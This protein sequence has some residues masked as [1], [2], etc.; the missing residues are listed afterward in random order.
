MITGGRGLPTARSR[1]RAIAAAC[2]AI[3]LI[4]ESRQVP[5]VAPW[6]ITSS[7]HANIH[8][9]NFIWL[10]SVFLVVI[11]LYFGV[12]LAVETRRSERPLR[13]ATGE[14]RTLTR[15]LI[16]PAGG[17]L[18]AE[19][20]QAVREVLERCGLAETWSHL[21]PVLIRRRSNS[22]DDEYW[23]SGSCADALADHWQAAG[24]GRRFCRA[25][26]GL[27]TGFGLFL[28]FL[29]ILIALM[30]V[31][32]QGTQVVGV[33]QLINGLSGKFLSSVI[34]L[35]LA[36]TFT[37]YEDRMALRLTRAEGALARGLDVVFPRLSA[38][39]LISELQQG[40]GD[41][42]R[43]FIRDFGGDLAERLKQSLSESMGPTL[44]RM[45]SVIE[46]LG[47]TLRAAEAGKQDSFNAS[48]EQIT[49]EMGRA[50]GKALEALTERFS[51]AL[52]GFA[53]DQI[54]QQFSTLGAAAERLTGFGETFGKIQ[55]EMTL[56]LRTT[57]DEL[58]RTVGQCSQRM[59]EATA[60]SATEASGAAQAVVSQAADWSAGVA[61]KLEGLLEREEARLGTVQEVQR[62]LESAA[63]HFESTVS[64]YANLNASLASTVHESRSV[65]QSV[66]AAA[67][68]AKRSQQG[69]QRVA[70]D[71]AAWVRELN[72]GSTGQ[73]ALWDHVRASME[74]YRQLFEETEKHAAQLLELLQREAQNQFQQTRDGYDLLLTSF[75]NHF[76]GAVKKLGG[77]VEELADIL[78]DA[79]DRRAQ[80]AGSSHGRS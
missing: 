78:D 30:D 40:A 11:A 58:A 76:G 77:A 28:T 32:M 29:A 80:A 36:I 62:A 61:R 46:E 37:I 42:V 53:G 31:H 71:S 38:V 66:I 4:V 15:G 56:G 48:I 72:A 20:F 33:Q 52:T 35:F 16:L 49:S 9:P 17:G 18:P 10:G 67:E 51:T 70:E 57:V 22:G 69:M 64:Q 47:Q 44:Q 2:I 73:K 21:A 27:I 7:A 59:S 68:T 45:V 75:D 23:A 1:P 3:R 60:K 43:A 6:L 39:G 13:R 5:N 26:P 55:S 14:F 24:A 12:Q 74:E 25:L 63:A 41:Q 19:R 65:A 34:A 79:T 50:V 54:S 8:A